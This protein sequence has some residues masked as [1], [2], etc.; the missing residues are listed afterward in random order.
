MRRF[1]RLW[2]ALSAALL[3]VVPIIAI[4]W[5]LG[6]LLDYYHAPFYV[7]VVVIMLFGTAFT[8]WLMTSPMMTRWITRIMTWA[9]QR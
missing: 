9:E 6:A 7:A 1:F 3:L 2:V 8:A 5:S 4:I